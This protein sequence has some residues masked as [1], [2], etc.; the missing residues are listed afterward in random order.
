MTLPAPSYAPR[1]G[2]YYEYPQYSYAPPV[3]Y[4]PPA[5]GYGYR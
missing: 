1:A 4:G 5:Y 3:A 2:G